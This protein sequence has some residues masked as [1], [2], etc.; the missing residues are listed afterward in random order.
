MHLLAAVLRGLLRSI[1]ETLPSSEDEAGAFLSGLT[2]GFVLFW[3]ILVL[4][5]W[6]WFTSHGLRP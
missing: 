3:A 5:T 1:L 2:W 6:S 4:V